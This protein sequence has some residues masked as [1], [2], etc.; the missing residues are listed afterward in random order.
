MNLTTKTQ[1]APAVA[2]VQ[3]AKQIEASAEAACAIVDE[4]GAICFS[5]QMDPVMKQVRAA[6]GV[7]K[8]LSICIESLEANGYSEVWMDT[9][10]AEGNFMDFISVTPADLIGS[11]AHKKDVCMQGLLDTMATWCAKIW[12]WIVK[13][14]TMLM[15][16]LRKCNF[17]TDADVKDVKN[18]WGYIIA[19]Y[20][21]DRIASGYGYDPKEA[22]K[23]YAELPSLKDLN[24][25]LNL[26]KDIVTSLDNAD[27]HRMIDGIGQ[28]PID[29]INTTIISKY[30]NIN[31]GLKIDFATGTIAFDPFVTIGIDFIKWVKENQDLNIAHIEL[32]NNLRS[33][34]NCVDNTVKLI[35]R[36]LANA[37]SM[38]AAAKK[39]KHT[40]R[41]AD[42]S[43]RANRAQ[44]L[45]GITNILI[46]QISIINNFGQLY[47]QKLAQTAVW[48]QNHK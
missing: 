4:L 29:I 2:P 22:E 6:K 38:A 18:S 23:F 47:K 27:V 11:E 1:K 12:E 13:A 30:S 24:D 8:D 16:Y 15:E 20:A 5:E 26:I 21:F 39:L 10:N 44:S 19:N 3:Q 45:L 17:F 41:L 35:Q 48:L 46:T 28:K 31:H 37:K 25:R 14:Y 40:T 7:I 33:N 42:E 32:S 43:A 36:D 34:G 9:V